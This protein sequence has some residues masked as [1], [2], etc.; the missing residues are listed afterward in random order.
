MPSPDYLDAGRFKLQRGP[1]GLVEDSRNES[2]ETR[3]SYDEKYRSKLS[4]SN[5]VT[6][7]QSLYFSLLQKQN[8]QSFPLPHYL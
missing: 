6:F 2:N 8:C 3:E 5:L 7:N 1:K 4:V